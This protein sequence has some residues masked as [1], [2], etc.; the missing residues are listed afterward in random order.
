MIRIQATSKKQVTLMEDE[1]P[2][3]DFYA[4]C[5]NLCTSIF[6]KRASLVWED[7]VLAKGLFNH[8][9]VELAEDQDD[10]THDM[11]GFCQFMMGLGDWWDEEDR[12]SYWQ[13]FNN[14]HLPEASIL[15]DYL[16]DENNIDMMKI[17]FF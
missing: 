14:N 11:R 2:V 12:Y 8:P 17:S 6:G 4:I 3:K 7:K 9:T 15:M 5:L 13:L 1:M 16:G 10:I